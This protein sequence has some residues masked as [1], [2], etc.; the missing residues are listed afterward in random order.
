MFLYVGMGMS[1]NF[2]S[3]G[4]QLSHDHATQYKFVLQSFTLWREIMANMPKLWMFADSDMTQQD[5]RLVDTGE[6]EV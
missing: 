2:M 6:C 1:M 3:G 4:A 5:Y